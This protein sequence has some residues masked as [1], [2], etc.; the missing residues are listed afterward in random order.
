[1][2]PLVLALGACGEDTLSPVAFCD[3]A[4]RAICHRLVLDACPVPGLD[5]EEIRY[6]D[7]ASCEHDELLVCQSL[8]EQDT[9]KF[10]QAS[11]AE[12]VSEIRSAD[13]AAASRAEFHAC[14]QV[15][16]N[17]VRPVLP[18]DGNTGA[19]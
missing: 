15:F 13:C 19:P 12:C 5:R 16:E 2:L 3:Q 9:G 1:M 4:T 18:L 6:D 7:Q 10:D 17:Q 8:L 14:D 11:A